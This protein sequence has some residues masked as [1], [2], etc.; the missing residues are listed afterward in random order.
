MS[1]SDRIVPEH[2]L[3]RHS[4]RM[5]LIYEVLNEGRSIGTLP[6]ACGVE[7]VSISAG[8]APSLNEGRSI[9]SGDTIR[10]DTTR[11]QATSGLRA[12]RRPEHKLRRHCGSVPSADTVAYRELQPGADS[13]KAGACNSR[14]PAAGFLDLPAQ[15]STKAGA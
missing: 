11:R 1:R 14:L 2:K 10:P 12:Q 9:N 5:R 15:R 3:R 8:A 6:P 4:C 7:R 13:T